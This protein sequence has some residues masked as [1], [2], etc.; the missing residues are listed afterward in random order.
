MDILKQSMRKLKM[1]SASM[2]WG[3]KLVLFVRRN[4]SY[5]MALVF[6]LS[7]WG[8]TLS[9]LRTAYFIAYVKLAVEK[10]TQAS[11]Y[12][13]ERILTF[14]NI[15]A[16]ANTVVHAGYVCFTGTLIIWCVDHHIDHRLRTKK[17]LRHLRK[18]ARDEYQILDENLRL[19]VTLTEK[20]KL[21]NSTKSALKRLNAIILRYEQNAV[22]L[23]P[24]LSK[25]EKLSET[26]DNLLDLFEDVPQSPKDKA[27]QQARSIIFKPKT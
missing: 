12:L 27:Y 1:T 26:E 6:V 13:Y 24:N 25:R 8:A 11:A 9:G 21:L 3:T 15:Q 2:V 23:T 19:M 16:L 4:I 7:N 17:E 10:N 5:T 22:Q 20:E 18:W 14:E